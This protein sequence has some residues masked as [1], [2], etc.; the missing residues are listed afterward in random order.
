MDLDKLIQSIKTS[1]FLLDGVNKY[2][3]HKFI[4]SKV[5]ANNCLVL[6]NL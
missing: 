4:L 1:N 5:D 6:Y 2:K 3:I